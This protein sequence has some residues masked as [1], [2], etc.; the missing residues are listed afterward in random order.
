M[1]TKPLEQP[2]EWASNLAY[3]VGPKA[4]EDTKIDEAGAA[5][6]GHIPGLNFPTTANEL[7]AP[8]RSS[9]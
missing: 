4:T 6:D 3:S 7:S 5:P 2:S 8:S 1:P 9:N